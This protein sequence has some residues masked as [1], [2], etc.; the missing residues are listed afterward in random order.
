MHQYVSADEYPNT[1]KPGDMKGH[2]WQS[3]VTAAVELGWETLSCITPW[4]AQAVMLS[5]RSYSKCGYAGYVLLSSCSIILSETS[6]LFISDAMRKKNV[7]GIAHFCWRC[8]LTFSPCCWLLTWNQ[9]HFLSFFFPLQAQ[10][11]KC[12][13]DRM[14]F[15]LHHG[16]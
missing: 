11:E 16:T 6:W 7:S 3:S 12:D 8:L 15:D 13:K 2:C 5:P 14:V 1:R 4:G 9:A 10:Y